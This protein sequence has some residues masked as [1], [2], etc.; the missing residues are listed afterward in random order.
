MT[1]AWSPPLQ[2]GLLLEQARLHTAPVMAAK[3]RARGQAAVAAEYLLTQKG[4]AVAPLKGMLTE[5]WM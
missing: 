4:W 1:Q 2:P 3:A 5:P